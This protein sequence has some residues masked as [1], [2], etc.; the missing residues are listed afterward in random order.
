MSGQDRVIIAYLLLGVLTTT[1]LTFRAWRSFIRYWG[2]HRDLAI[3]GLIYFV[4]AWPYWVWDFYF[5]SWR[6]EE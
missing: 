3:A 2:S 1:I 4:M 6:K 5:G